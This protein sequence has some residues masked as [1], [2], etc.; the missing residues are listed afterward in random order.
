MPVRNFWDVPVTLNAKAH[1]QSMN[2]IDLVVAVSGGKHM[3]LEGQIRDKK[4]L[5]AVTGKTADFPEFNKDCEVRLSGM[6][7]K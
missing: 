2:Q 7:T 6:I 5:R 1:A 4:S 3:S